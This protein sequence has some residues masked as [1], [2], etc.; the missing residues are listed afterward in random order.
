[1]KKE[2]S[3]TVESFYKKWGVKFTFRHTGKMQGMVS[4]SKGSEK[5]P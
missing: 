3:I 2:K 4:L 1:M 5:V